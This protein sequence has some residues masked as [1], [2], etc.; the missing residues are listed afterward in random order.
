MKPIL[1]VHVE[2]G[3]H[4]Y[5]WLPGSAANVCEGADPALLVSRRSKFNKCFLTAGLQLDHA[6]SRSE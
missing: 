6:T 5:L 2:P 1:S 4:P 3:R